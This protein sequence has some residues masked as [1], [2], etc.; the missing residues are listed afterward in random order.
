M[1]QAV[2]G[3]GRGQCC[4][5][6]WGSPAGLRDPRVP[7]SRPVAGSR[8]RSL[9]AP[10]SLLSLE[11]PSGPQHRPSQSGRQPGAGGRGAC[12]QGVW[13]GS[14]GIRRPVGGRGRA[15]GGSVGSPSRGGPGSQRQVKVEAAAAAAGRGKGGRGAAG[16]GWRRRGRWRVEGGLIPIPRR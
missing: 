6:A 7:H 4:G 15:G 12:L 13:G 3:H 16:P 5:R 10:S 2:P 11:L 8:D 14:A 9:E 1:R